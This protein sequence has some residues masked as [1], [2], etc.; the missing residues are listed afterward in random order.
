M[1]RPGNSV[2][3]DGHEAAKRPSIHHH[4]TTPSGSTSPNCPERRPRTGTAPALKPET[5]DALLEAIAKARVWIDD[6][7]E[8][9]V[10]SL[11]EIARRERKVG[12][13]A[14]LLAPLAFVSPWVVFAIIDGMA[15][16]Q[17]NV[18]ALAIALPY[19]WAEQKRRKA[20]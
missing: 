19:C 20:F 7:V 2:H 12:R 8:G 10:N 6:L 5:R 14:R 13:H 11:A 1:T 4:R 3:A 15:V 16:A 17:T 18:T 9:R